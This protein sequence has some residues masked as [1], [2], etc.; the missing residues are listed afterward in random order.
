MPTAEQAIPSISVDANGVVTATSVQ[1]EGYVEG[2]TKT[3]VEQLATQGAVTVEPSRDTKTV[4]DAGVYTTGA[5]VVSA[6]PD[7]YQDVSSVTATAD[8]VLSSKQFVDADGN[9]VTGNIP[10]VEQAVP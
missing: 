9:I 2:G 6:I 1:N 4:V 3:S 8:D 5:I 7:E 10:V